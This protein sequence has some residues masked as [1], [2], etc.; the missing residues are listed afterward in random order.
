MKINTVFCAAAALVLSVSAI[1]CSGSK[2][3]A[4]EDAE[5]LRPD[6]E[7]IDSVSYL[8]GILCG[9]YIRSFGGDLL[10]M[11]EVE[12]GREDYL[13]AK[14]LPHTQFFDSNFKVQPS[15]MNQLFTRYV[16]AL[17]EYRAAVNIEKEEAFLA[18]NAAKKGVEVS[19]SGLQYKIERAGGE[20]KA[21]A[22]DTVM[23]TYALYDVEGVQFDGKT[24]PTAFT[25]RS[26]SLQGWKEAIKMLGEGGKGRFFLPSELAYGENGYRDIAPNATIILDLEVHEIRKP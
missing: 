22:G 1:S 21:A 17:R 24:E 2:S 6:R 15:E 13:K 3:C 19:E 11:S 7:T 23:I 9:D 16:K 20:V 12:K 4:S 25:D 10:N 8:V 26:I 18:D 5:A 14:G